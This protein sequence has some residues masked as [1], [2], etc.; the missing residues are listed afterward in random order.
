MNI[1]VL[2]TKLLNQ[3]LKDANYK[4][5]SFEYDSK[6]SRY[7]L[8]IFDNHNPE[9]ELIFFLHV[10]DPTSISH[11]VRYKKDGTE[12][13]IDKKHNYYLEAEK[14][15]SRFIKGFSLCL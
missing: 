7:C 2:N 9:D 8:S 4:G 1:T 5:W 14:L 3:Q 10:F 12:N 6:A 15:I 13:P 11:A